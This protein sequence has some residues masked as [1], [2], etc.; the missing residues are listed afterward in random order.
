[1]IDELMTVSGDCLQERR[2]VLR[3]TAGHAKARTDSLSTQHRQD[4]R[5]MPGIGASIER[6]RYRASRPRTRTHNY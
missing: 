5:G 4:A 2:V 1:M 3:P 6:Q